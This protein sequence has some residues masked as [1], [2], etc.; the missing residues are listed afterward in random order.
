[1][2]IV[3]IF[4]ILLLLVTCINPISLQRNNK[5]NNY[6][7]HENS[8]YWVSCIRMKIKHF[9]NSFL[10]IEKRKSFD[11]FT[12][13]SSSTKLT[14]GH[15]AKGRHMHSITAPQQGPSIRWFSLMT[16][17]VSTDLSPVLWHANRSRLCPQLHISCHAPTK[18]PKDIPQ[19]DPLGHRG[20]EQAL[21]TRSSCSVRGQGASWRLLIKLCCCCIA[22]SSDF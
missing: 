22:G 10:F 1:M 12:N 21:G 4:H 9:S 15:P 20:R 18:H 17:R 6:L 11:D 13:S 8:I 5:A 16:G 19:L 14:E 2:L 3:V 7:R